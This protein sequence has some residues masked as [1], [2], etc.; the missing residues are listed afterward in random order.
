MHSRS[1]IQTN[2]L[3]TVTWLIKD[4]SKNSYDTVT[5]KGGNRDATSRVLGGKPSYSIDGTPTTV[6]AVAIATVQGGVAGFLFRLIS[7]VHAVE[8][9]LI[10]G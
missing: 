9:E 3:L 8:D 5:T 1:V 7:P 2:F 10:Q 6:V 4:L